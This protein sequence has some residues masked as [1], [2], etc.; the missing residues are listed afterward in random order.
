MLGFEKIVKK[1][2]PK[3]SQFRLTRLNSDHKLI[4][5]GILTVFLFVVLGKLA[6]AAK[7]II[8]AWRYGVSET[9]DAYLFVFNLTQWPVAI[10]GG[11]VAQVLIPVVA[12]VRRSTPEQIPGFRAELLGATVG[13]GLILGTIFGLTLP[14]LFGKPWFGL[15]TNQTKIALYIGHYLAWIIPLGLLS[16]LLS[17]WTLAANR[18]LNTLFEGV[19]ALFIL[20]AVMMAEGP[21]PLVWG[22][23][24]GFLLQVCLLAVSLAWFSELEFPKLGFQS[25]HWQAILGGLGL[26]IIGQTLISF[27]TLVDQFFAVRL[28]P[29]A[30]A[31][32]GYA[33]RV[34]S[35][36][37]SL[38]ATVIA[39]A[40]L[41]VLSRTHVEGRGMLVLIALRWAGLF[42]VLGMIVMALI[43]LWAQPI[44][45]TFYQRGQFTS[46]NT[47]QVAELLRYAV[48]Q[49]PF[50]L[51][52]ITLVNAFLSQ[53]RQ[54]PLIILSGSGLLVKLVLSFFLITTL[55]LKGL[56]L[57]TA[58]VYLTTSSVA[59]WMLYAKNR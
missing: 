24:L 39:R 15:S 14:W 48:I 45:E 17:A 22:T 3:R 13:L 8:I 21:V 28:G 46:N 58:G 5:R 44:V 57:A 10:V 31:T 55:G 6:G 11:G 49:V 35:L 50:Y 56:L 23:L 41:P 43:M 29:G 51:V 42:F 38:S 4:V 18:H 36:V 1:L 12:R 7:E 16:H 52:S 20:L 40:M 30:L 2:L 47:Q 26:V 27:V 59:L 54:K 19:P 25:S 32:L 34:L 53:G 33:N 9:V 37:L